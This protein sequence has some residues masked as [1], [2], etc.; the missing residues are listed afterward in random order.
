MADD[1]RGWRLSVLAV[2]RLAGCWWLRSWAA[3]AGGLL[4]VPSDWRRPVR[5]G[6]RWS[7]VLRGG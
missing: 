7:S 2:R 6:L 3:R 4:L 1:G 5:F